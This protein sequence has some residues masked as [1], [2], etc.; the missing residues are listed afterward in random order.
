MN[1]RKNSGFTLMEILVVI[2]IIVIL[3]GLL[4]PALSRANRQAKKVECINNLKQIGMALNQY[5]LDN[6]GSYPANLAALTT[7]PANDPYLPPG[8]TL[9]QCSG[10]NGAYTYNGSGQTIGTVNATFNMCQCPATSHPGS[11]R[12]ILYGDGHVK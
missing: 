2:S 1:I 10:D 3:A 7:T 11:T 8:T 4:T 5:A 6:N 9:L 12:N